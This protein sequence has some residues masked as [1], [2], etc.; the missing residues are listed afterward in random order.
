MI[1]QQEF[2]SI[3]ADA[4]KR[5]AGDIRWQE[6]ENHSPALEFRVEVESDPGWPLV[7]VGRWN[8][9][10]GTLSYVLIHRSVGRIY[11]LDLGADHHNPTCQR[12]GEKHKHRWTEEFRDKKAYVPSDITASWDGP[13][14]AWDQFCREANI[15]HRGRMHPPGVQEE[16]PL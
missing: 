16:L 7:L 3:L 10:A 9:R 8:P 12:V 14:E 11:G 15:E 13:V 6:D 5:I 4:S 1:T 2:E